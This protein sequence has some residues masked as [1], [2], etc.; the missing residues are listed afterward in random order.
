MRYIDAIDGFNSGLLV[1]LEISLGA[2]IGHAESYIQFCRTCP[3]F[4]HKKPEPWT[5]G[6]EHFVTN[7]V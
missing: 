4:K 3:E 5:G 1:L 2:D 6:A 7:I